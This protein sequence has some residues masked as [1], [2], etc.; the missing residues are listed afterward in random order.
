MNIRDAMTDPVLFGRQFG[1][2]SWAAWRALLAGF[3]G[4]ALSDDE[5]AHWYALTGRNAPQSA[6]EELWQ[7]I[8]RRGGKSQCAALLAVYEAAFFDHQPQLAAGEV[9]TVRVMAADR[10]QARSV[11]RY[12][13]GLINGNNM[14][15]RMVAREDRESIELTNRAVIEVGTASYRTA[16][17]YTFAAVIADEIAFWRSEDSANPD[18]EIIAAVRPGMATLGGKLIALSSPYSKRG[19]L[20]D[21]YRRHFGQNSDV[22]VAQAPSRTMNPELPQSVVDREFERDP[23]SAKAEYQAQFRSDLESFLSRETVADLTRSEPL[24]IPHDW[25]RRYIA[26]VDPAGGGNDEFTLAIGHEDRQTKTMIVDA[27]YGQRGTPA[28]IVADYA[29]TLKQYRISR[30]T[31]DRYAGSW[32]ADEFK[33]NGITFEHSDSVR[34]DIYK[35]ALNVINSARVELPPD[36]RM[37]QQFV[38]LERRTSRSGKDTVDHPPGAHDDRANAVAGLI[39]SKRSGGTVFGILNH[40]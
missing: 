37:I 38:G 35:N 28:T 8:G 32:P 12:I 29:K 16:R 2:D 31:G 22:L 27:V 13:S 14:L 26:F 34:S 15:K 40:D 23:E 17:G 5:M 24:T 9:A 19:E 20:W 6:H 25:S 10:A 36:D 11:M 4:L 7:V 1:G 30:V 33:R 21:N 18:S 3:Y 39:A